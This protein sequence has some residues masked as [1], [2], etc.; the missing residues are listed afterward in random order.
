MPEQAQFLQSRGEHTEFFRYLR[1]GRKDF[2]SKIRKRVHVHSSHTFPEPDHLG[3]PSCLKR[4]S[5][6]PIRATILKYARLLL[7][8]WPLAG[9]RRR[10][11]RRISGRVSASVFRYKKSFPRARLSVLNPKIIF[12]VK[13]FVQD[14]FSLKR[15]S[16]SS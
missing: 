10:F 6:S 16:L 1:A 11:F 14:N 5:E 4:P 9:Q 15:V 3:H 2:C 8:G 13:V 7:R 12:V